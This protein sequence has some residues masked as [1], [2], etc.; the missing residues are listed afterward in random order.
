MPG[1]GG[2]VIGWIKRRTDEIGTVV[3]GPSDAEIG[4][5]V[6]VKPERGAATPL[7]RQR[8]IRPNPS[9]PVPSNTREVGSGTAAEPLKLPLTLAVKPAKVV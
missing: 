2:W 6:L 9:I 8:R 3:L 4:L 7:Q 1:E 5:T